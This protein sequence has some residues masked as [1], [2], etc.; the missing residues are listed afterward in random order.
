MLLC[1]VMKSFVVYFGIFIF[2]VELFGFEHLR[3][4]FLKIRFVE[5]RI[6]LRQQRS[7]QLGF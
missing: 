5:N 7:I 1:W 2:M 4:E 3:K 6:I